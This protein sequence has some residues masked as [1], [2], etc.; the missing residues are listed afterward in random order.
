MV[1]VCLHRTLSDLKITLIGHLVES[2]LATREKLACIAMAG[3][4][5]SINSCVAFV[6]NVSQEAVFELTRWE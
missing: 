2:I 1:G 5:T 4:K 6:T 3:K